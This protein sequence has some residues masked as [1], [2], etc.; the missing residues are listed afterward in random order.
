M[1]RN[2]ENLLTKMN[3]EEQFIL[4]NFLKRYNLNSKFPNDYNG[5]NNKANREVL[6][7]YINEYLKDFFVTRVEIAE[8]MRK[9]FENICEIKDIK[10]I[11]FRKQE[12]ELQIDLFRTLQGKE[13]M[14][15]S[16]I[17]AKYG[18]SKADSIGKFKSQMEAENYTL[19]GN[20]MKLPKVEMD[21][22]N[23]KRYTN[24]TITPVFL[25]LS[26]GEIYWIIKSLMTQSGDGDI[27]L[28]I[29][30]NIGKRFYYQLSE[31]GRKQVKDGLEKAGINIDFPDDLESRV[32]FERKEIDMVEREILKNKKY[33]NYIGDYKIVNEN[34]IYRCLEK[35]NG[36]T[37]IVL[38]Q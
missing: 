14:S 16:D 26:Q 23:I 9:Y 38:N 1:E 37:Q 12:T 20:K 28:E 24:Q 5:K 33:G 31:Y 6:E 19:L 29:S 18:Y 35:E 22:D 36:E 13:K 21:E 3:E 10:I 8:I 2:F 32:N 7:K 34:D 25:G 15:Q 11:P 17:A 4:K 27:L 30:K